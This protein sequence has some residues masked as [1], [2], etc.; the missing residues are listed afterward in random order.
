MKQ[1]SLIFAILFSLL[2][3]GC[4]AEQPP[5][6][7]PSPIEDS[8]EPTPAQTPAETEDHVLLTLEAR[9]DD[10]R[11]L[12]LEAVG[13]KRPG[14]DQWGVR[15][16]RVWDGADWIQ[17]VSVQE[18][19]DAG[20]VSGVVGEGYTD[21]WSIEAAMAVRD[22]NFDGCDDL[23]LF[24]WVCNNTIPHYYWLW[25]REAQQFAYAFCLQGAEPDPE[26]KE[27][28]SEY[29]EDAARYCRD[30]YR[31]DETGAPAL[32]RRDAEN[33]ADMKLEHYEMINGQLTLT[34]TEGLDGSGTAFEADGAALHRG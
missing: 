29:K 2:C 5:A 10:G 6:A 12:R 20:G 15:E 13:K 1:F 18:A 4:G 33:Y 8:A 7:A 28:C 16:V 30:Y 27:I 25:D 32:V 17:T 21:C 9:V 19:I 14:M 23:D 3:A 22:M 31:F 11:L 26:R 34:G 24:G